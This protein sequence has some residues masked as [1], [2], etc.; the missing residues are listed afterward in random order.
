MLL[1]E[2]R[3]QHLINGSNNKVCKKALL[4]AAK[5]VMDNQPFRS[6]VFLCGCQSVS[7]HQGSIGCVQVRHAMREAN[8]DPVLF[9]LLFSPFHDAVEH[10]IGGRLCRQSKEDSTNT[11]HGKQ[12]CGHQR[13]LCL[14]K[15]HRGFQNHQSGIF[16]CLNCRYHC[17]L[18]RI[19]RKAE[20]PGCLFHRITA[21]R[22][23]PRR[24]ESQLLPC[25]LKP[26]FHIIRFRFFHR[27]QRKVFLVACDPVRHDDKPGE[28]DSRGLRQV[29]Q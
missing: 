18:H 12:I 19:G 1:P 5:P 17:A 28:D 16:T 23:M 4:A 26:L 15:P 21:L 20:Q 3:H 10:G 11:P 29:R 27:D 9:R 7:R 25:L 8:T 2:S 22:Y 14:S 6:F 13:G 24:R